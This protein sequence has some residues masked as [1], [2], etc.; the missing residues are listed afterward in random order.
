MSKGTI[1]DAVIK[2]LPKYYSQIRRLDEF[3]IEKVSSSELANYLGITA[4]QVRQDF[5]NFGGFGQQGYGYDVKNLK[6]E[7][8]Q[9]LGLN[10]EYDMII[11]GAGHIGGALAGYRGFKKDGFSIKALFDIAVKEESINEI[12]VYP[13]D[14]LDEYLQEN[15]IDIAIISVQSTAADEVAQELV[16]NGIKTIWNFAPTDLKVPDDVVVENI[17]MSESLFV[18]SYRSNNRNN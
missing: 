10:R 15:K 11:I 7:L 2:R 14:K 1:S 8:A 13:M 3:G 17:S 9:I 6:K 18:L 5:Y 16:K 4:S 12:P